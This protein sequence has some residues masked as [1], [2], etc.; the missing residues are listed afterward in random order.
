[1]NNHSVPLSRASRI[2]GGV[3]T[4]QRHDSAHK[5]VTGTAVYIDD[6]PEP[7]GTLH[8]GLGFSSIAHGRIKSMDLDAVHKAPGVVDV[9]TWKDVP[10]E[11]DVSP[12]G[13]HDDPAEQEFLASFLLAISRH[14]EPPSP[15]QSRHLLIHAAQQLRHQPLSS[16]LCEIERRSL[17]RCDRPPRR[18]SPFPPAP[19]SSQRVQSARRILLSAFFYVRAASRFAHRYPE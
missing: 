3:A 7:E 18:R 9:L 5:H 6:I 8:V 4:D 16:P 1:M 19:P 10:G 15:L 11:N 14:E 2:K 12:S 17:R 13:A